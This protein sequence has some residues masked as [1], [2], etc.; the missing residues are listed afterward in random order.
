MSRAEQ[1]KENYEQVLEELKEACVQARRNPEE[2]KLVAVSKKHSSKDIEFLAQLGQKDFGENY[3]QEVLAKQEELKNLSLNW[4]F[5][6]ALQTN[7]AKYVAGKF[8]LIHSVDRV[9]LARELDKQ[10]KKKGVIQEILIQVNLG[11]EEQKAGVEEEGLFSLVEE[12]LKLKQ[13]KLKGLMTLPP[14]WY[15]EKVR[16][17]FARLRELKEAIEKR[18][19]L[20]LPHLSMGMTQDFKE[21]ISEGATLVRIGTRIFGPRI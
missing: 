14:C 8:S 20:S 1:L 12:V 9:K 15:G 11:K 6:G 17:L 21:A 10:A 19:A 7:K 18:F 16:P 4:H 2:V 13:L 5:I 3:V